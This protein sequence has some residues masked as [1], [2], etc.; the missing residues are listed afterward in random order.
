MKYIK[1][2]Y[3]SEADF[4]SVNLAFWQN[5]CFRGEQA[6]VGSEQASVGSVLRARRI[7]LVSTLSAGKNL[8]ACSKHFWF[9]FVVFFVA[10]FFIDHRTVA[11]STSTSIH[12]V[13]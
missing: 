9:V 6:S 4:M 5:L 12:Y 1:H 13:L 11:I 10:S 8:R 3:S 7:G 2:I